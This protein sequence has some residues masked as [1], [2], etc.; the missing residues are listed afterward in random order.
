MS[1]DASWYSNV[2]ISMPQANTAHPL[3]KMDGFVFTVNGMAH[4]IDDMDLENWGSQVQLPDA[5]SQ[6]VYD[7]NDIMDYQDLEFT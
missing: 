3:K 4:D 6:T 7:D 5:P 1:N 2:P